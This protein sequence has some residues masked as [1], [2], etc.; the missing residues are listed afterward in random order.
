MSDNPSISFSRVNFDSL[1]R[2]ESI[3]ELTVDS[4]TFNNS[5]HS[6][7]KKSVSFI[8]NE[9]VNEDKIM[10]DVKVINKDA[11]RRASLIVANDNISV[12]PNNNDQPI[13]LMNRRCS[14]RKVSLSIQE[15][16]VFDVNT[17]PTNLKQELFDE[18]NE[19]ALL[20]M[21]AELVNY[22]L[23]NAVKIVINEIKAN[24]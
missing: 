11:I 24:I 12:N 3:D 18:Q 22:I 9:N 4:D 5:R 17:L 1:K 2:N 6:M 8:G 14:M 13:H 19:L 16:K 15:G 20:D 7:R 23:K 21:S 10:N